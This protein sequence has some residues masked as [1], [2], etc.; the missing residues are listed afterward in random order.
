MSKVQFHNPV[1]VA[2]DTP[3][4][5]AALDLSVSLKPYVGGLKLGLEFFCANG[6]AGIEALKACD[7]PVFL[8]LKL[9][10]IPNTVA[11]ALRSLA[12]LAPAFLTL[13]AQGGEEMMKRAAE[14]AR[15]EAM[16]AG[17]SAPKLLGVTIMTSLNADDLRAQGG[18]G[19]VAAQVERLAKLTQSAGLDGIVCSP[20]EVEAMRKSLGSDM[21]L[22]VPGIR[23]E[24]ADK[25]DQKRV[26]TPKEAL[27]KGADILVIGRPITQA[28]DPQ[29]AAK[30]IAAQLY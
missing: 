8:D 19:N 29:A 12:P 28:D 22:V 7:L 17:V 20:H 3:K 15:E 18:D 5:E 10:D 14:T 23:P 21:I 2:L 25:G 9:H 13:H 1:F 24:G 26:M 4:V 11:G 6:P 27:A 16:K 30:S